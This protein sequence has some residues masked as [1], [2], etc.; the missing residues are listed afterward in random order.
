LDAED[1]TMDTALIRQRAE[2][3]LSAAHEARDPDERALLVSRA[4]ELLNLVMLEELRAPAC[5]APGG[6]NPGP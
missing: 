3:L 6:P 5:A 4:A 1:A 2:G